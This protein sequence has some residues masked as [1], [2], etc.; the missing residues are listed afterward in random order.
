MD[1]LLWLTAFTCMALLDVAW[2]LYMRASTTG[3]PW[4]AALWAGAIHGLSSST[5]ILY[6]DDHRYLSATM[7]GA[8]LGTWAVVAYHARNRKAGVP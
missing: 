4:P 5:V 8:V 1:W 6:T 3:A 2:V 7:L